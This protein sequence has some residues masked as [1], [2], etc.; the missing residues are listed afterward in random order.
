MDISETSG[1]YAPKIKFAVL[2]SL[3]W[4]RYVLE[5]VTVL[6]EILLRSR[7]KLRNETFMKNSI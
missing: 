7:V 3:S 4:A 2:I 1:E 5:K 6:I